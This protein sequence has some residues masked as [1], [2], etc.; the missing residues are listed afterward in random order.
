MPSLKSIRNRI[1][2]VKN[3][4]KITKAMKLV[5]AARLRRAQDAMLQAR[6]YAA[7]VR[8]VMGDVVA[9]IAATTDEPP[10]PLMARRPVKKV[11]LVVI[12]SDRGLAGAYNSGLNRRVERLLVDEGD[13]YAIE[14]HTVGRKAREYF[15]RRKV[16][17]TREHAG[18]ASATALERAR[19]IGA[20][21]TAAFLAGEVDEVRLVYN[22]FKS[23][24]SQVV[25]VQTLLPLPAAELPA[26][27]GRLDFEY[28]PSQEE[29]LDTLIPL[30]VEVQVYQSMLEA[31]ASEFAARMSAMDNASK[32][33]K[34]MIGRL[35]L[36]YNRA[37]QAAITKEL[38]EIVGGAE[39]LKG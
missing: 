35:T 27:E 26:G 18:V 20:E 5:A 36:S 7:H 19:E 29:V 30:Y 10:H 6:P 24:I 11:R 38:M 25:A 1:A 39:A 15:R 16:A 34:E 14:L 37:R 12:S 4:Q 32:N 9:R 22:E 23:A 13:Q 3:T 2:S 8:E 31:V 17:L 21:S 33:A 28:E